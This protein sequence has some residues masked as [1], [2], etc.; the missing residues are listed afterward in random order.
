MHSCM[1]KTPTLDTISKVTKTSLINKIY[2]CLFETKLLKPIIHI[3]KSK[4]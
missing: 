3:N 2:N 1:T 4:N